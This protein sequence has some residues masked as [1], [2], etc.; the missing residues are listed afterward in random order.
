MKEERLRDFNMQADPYE[1]TLD[2]RYM[3]DVPCLPIL[4]GGRLLSDHIF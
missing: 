4:P 1:H 3:I 2:V